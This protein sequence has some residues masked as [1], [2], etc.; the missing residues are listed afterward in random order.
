MLNDYATSGT[1]TTRMCHPESIRKG[2]ANR[3]Y[4]ALFNACKRKATSGNSWN[5]GV[6]RIWSIT[7]EEFLKFT[8]V[9]CCHYCEDVI[10]WP[11][12]YGRHDEQGIRRNGSN[13]DRVDNLQDYL[14]TN[15][16][17][18][19]WECN[20]TKR[21]LLTYEEMLA[22]GRMRRAARAADSKNS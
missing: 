8:E 14:A 7:Y 21:D 10:H 6:G 19:C 16:V 3:P 1:N 12:P 20:R 4:E 5:N 13:L 15:C 17:V 9:R 18:A 11:L 2:F 22:V